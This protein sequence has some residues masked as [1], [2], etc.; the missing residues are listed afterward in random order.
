MFR[1]FFVFYRALMI[2]TERDA[3]M[4]LNQ[5]FEEAAEMLAVLLVAAIRERHEKQRLSG[6]EQ[7]SA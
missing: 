5:N 6:T 3:G 2:V 4:D 1:A 7:E